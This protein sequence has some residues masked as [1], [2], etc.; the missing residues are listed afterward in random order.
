[1]DLFFFNRILGW[2]D[3]EKLVYPKAGLCLPK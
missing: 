3:L 1:M 2:K